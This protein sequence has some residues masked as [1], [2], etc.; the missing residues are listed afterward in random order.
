MRTIIGRRHLAPWTRS[1]RVIT[2]LL[3]VASLLAAAPPEKGTPA[4][5]QP[6]AKATDAKEGAKKPTNRLARETSPYLL[7]HA[8]NPVDWYPWGEEALAKAKAEGKLIFLSIGYSSCYWCHVMERESFMD[9]EVAA[10]LNKHFVCIKVDREERPDID[11]IYMKALQVM[12]RRGGWPLTMILTPEARPIVGGTYFPTRDKPIDP[13]PPADQPQKV[14]G[15]ITLLK[16]LRETWDKE[17]R[18]VRAHGENVAAAVK[19]AL[20]RS[21]LAPDPLPA[22]LLTE[23]LAGI[24]DEYDPEFGGFGFS[25]ADLRRPKFPDP[26]NLWFLLDAATRA[27][28]IPARKMLDLTLDQMARGGICDHLGGGFHR[29]STD[30]FWRIPHFEKMLYDN[31]Q[32]TS[33]YS[34][35]YKL[36][37]NA[38]QRRIVDE[39]LAFVE[40]ELTSPEGAFYA[41]LDAETQASEGDYYVWSAE[42]LKKLL[43]PE[44]LALVGRVY[45]VAGKPNFE[46]R[47]ALL[48]P[49]PV[50]ELAAT[51]GV[52]ID[53][54]WKKLASVRKKLLAARSL[55][56]R[57][58]TDVKILTA[59]NGL[60]IR[61]LADAGRLLEEPRY[62]ERAA[63]AADFVLVKLRTPAGRLLR[64]YTGGEAKLNAYLDDYAFLIDGLLALHE[65]TGERR[66]LTVADEL[67]KTQ[68]ELFWDDEQ[69]GFFFTS[70]DH[71]ALIARSKDPVDS[72]LPSGNGVSA[73]NL[74]ALAAALD[75]EEYL[76]RAERTVNA[77]AALLQDSPASAP[78]LAL[79]CQGIQE[80]RKA[81]EA[82]KAKAP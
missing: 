1:L 72:A 65:V 50:E 74:V 43:S 24:A 46:E 23:T 10:L 81:Q 5:S 44:E 28:K 66:W 55:R 16:L 29:Y 20:R 69:G 39:M 80:A 3:C 62:T 76:G 64:T 79:A 63:K 34:R 6:A 19:R 58:M 60:M 14:T 49:K 73:Q 61:G 30:R 18:E 7:L 54:F 12:G 42:E 13:P 67:M 15:L 33:V 26:S 56:E 21:S 40:R 8:H 36:T 57:P 37:G 48:L 78:R 52:T 4:A 25:M 59:W 82:K 9:A 41:A 31:A 68:L 32:L 2:T 77:F 45:G 35:A 70:D 22:S 17:P 11:E 27:E 51:E 38:E 53:A 75:R 47:Y 71:E